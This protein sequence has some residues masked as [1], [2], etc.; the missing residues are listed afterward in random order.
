MKN[1]FILLLSSNFSFGQLSLKSINTI[2]NEIFQSDSIVKTSNS[3]YNKLI[4]ISDI[5]KS[6][7]IVDI[8]FYIHYALSATTTLRRIYLDKGVWKTL[9]YNEWNNPP[10]IHN[11][12]LIAKFSLDSLYSKLLSHNFLTLQGQKNI[13]N[14]MN[15]PFVVSEDDGTMVE[16]RIRVMDG[17]GYTVEIKIRDKF[18]IYNF[19]NPKSY[20]EFYG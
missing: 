4:H 11:S 12:T 15:K 9:D 3:E 1:L 18:R 7:S 16:P 17:I 8:R 5:T 14:K 6:K 19:A 10:S 20:S 13:E 2:E